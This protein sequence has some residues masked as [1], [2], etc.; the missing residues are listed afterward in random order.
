MKQRLLLL[1]ATLLLAAPLNLQAADNSLFDSIDSNKDGS[2]SLEEFTKAPL[3]AIQTKSG[4][5]RLVPQ[6]TKNAVPLSKADKQGLFK[7]LDTDRSGKDERKEWS[8]A[9]PDGFVL[10]RF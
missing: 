6:N 3:A 5:K 8:H 10:F 4:H 1:S 2:I 9:S 7:K